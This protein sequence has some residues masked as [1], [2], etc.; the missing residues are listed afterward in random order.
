MQDLTAIDVLTLRAIRDGVI[1]RESPYVSTNVLGVECDRAHLSELQNRGL[2]RLDHAK[3]PVLT[4][5]GQVALD[6]LE[7]RR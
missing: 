1:Q 3:A 6:L 4:V 5:D 7:T 2:V